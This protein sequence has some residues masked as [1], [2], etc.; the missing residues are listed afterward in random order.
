MSGDLPDPCSGSQV[1]DNAQEVLQQAQTSYSDTLKTNLEKVKVES[2][3]KNAEITEDL[4]RSQA[5]KVW[6]RE[7]FYCLLNMTLSGGG[8]GQD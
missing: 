5:A 7:Y 3:Q 1:N 8:S 2:E 4:T 6:T